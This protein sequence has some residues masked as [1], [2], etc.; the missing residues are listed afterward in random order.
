MVEP[1]RAAELLRTLEGVGRRGY[2]YAWQLLRDEQDAL[3]A[4]QTALAAVW[5]HRRRLWPGRDPRGWFY[6]VLR[7]KCL[8]VLRRRCRSRAGGPVPDAADPTQPDPLGALDRQ[9]QL[10]G[11]RRALAE[12]PAE[13]REVLLLRDFHDLPYREIAAVLGIPAGTVM[14]RLHRARLTLRERLLAKE[15]PDER[16]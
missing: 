10:A 16:L 8:D 12:L 3:D 7:N 11:L 14:S 6:R 5:Q 13:L 4:V 9:E 15:R 2:A 1:D